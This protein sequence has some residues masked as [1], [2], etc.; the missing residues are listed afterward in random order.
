[1]SREMPGA[2][3]RQPLLDSLRGWAAFSVLT[4]HTFALSFL[5]RL[6]AVDWWATL[7]ANRAAVM[8]FFVLSGYVIGA[9][10]PS[11]WS[12]RSVARYGK[13][14]FIRIEPIYLVAILL[15]VLA[16]TNVSL[17]DVIGNGLFLQNFDADNPAGIRLL[18]GNE[19]LWSVH[20]EVIYYLLFVMW[21]KW[22]GTIPAFLVSGV[23]A[24]FAGARYDGIPAFWVSHATGVVFWL[25]GLLISRSPVA[26]GPARAGWIWPHVFW[27]HATQHAATITMML[28]GLHLIRGQRSWLTCGDFALLPGCITLV[29][30]AAQRRPRGMRY[31]PVLGLGAAVAGCVM[32][33][34]AH[35]SFAEP[36]W[37]A[38]LAFTLAGLVA[39]KWQTTRGLG[40]AERVGSF[41]YGLYAVHMPILILAFSWLGSGAGVLADL[42]CVVVT[43][44]VSFGLAALLEIRLQPK[45]R[46]WFL[47]LSERGAAVRQTGA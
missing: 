37:A 34:A 30:I 44:S 11:L 23:V 7:Q 43:W 47:R 9:T 24:S 16:N 4:Y 18:P 10:N 31:W 25:A 21:W 20:F 17:K 33:A 2:I 40:L 42:A 28:K 35:K 8:V 32:V 22:P 1:M 6:P 19:P 36:R 38:M 5:R 29:A 13:R 27:L 45:I 15:G 46:A 14:R 39:A 3:P 41:S 12:R 26:A